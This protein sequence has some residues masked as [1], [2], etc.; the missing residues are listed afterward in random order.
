[1][2]KYILFLLFIGI[3]TESC[4]K[5]DDSPVI[6]EEQEEMVEEEVVEEEVD[7]QVQD[8]MW[9]TLNAYYFWQGD[10]PVLADNR[11]ATFVEYETYLKSHP[12]PENFLLDEL[13]F[14]GDRFTFYSEDYKELTNLLSGIS[15]SNGLEFGLSRIGNSD[16]VFGFVEYVIKDSDASTKDIKRG[17]VFI[18]VNGTELNVNN[19]IDL[20]FGESDTYTL[21]MATIENNTISPNGKEVTLTKQEGLVEDP[22]LITDVFNIG[23]KRIGYLMYNSFTPGSGE[24][25]NSVFAEFKGQNVTD[26]VLD[27]RYNSGGRVS[28][29]IILS[30]LIYGTNTEELFYRD[31]YNAKIQALFEP[32]ELENN[33]VATTGTANGNS[34]AALN[35]LNLNT[36]YV[37]A[38]GAS[39]SS[40]ELVMVGLEPYMNVVHIG[41]TTVGKNEGSITF[42]DDPENG[43][44]YDPEREDRIN[45][46]NQWALQPIV[47]RSENSA[48][49]SDYS[50]GLIPDIELEEDVTNL[51]TLGDVNEPLLARA[52]QEITGIG[53]KRSFDVSMPVNLVSSSKLY[54]DRNTALILNGLNVGSKNLLKEI[55]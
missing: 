30:S 24:A 48:G 53:A 5:N 50:D 49:F 41:T 12:N 45:P 1:M 13:L 26:L 9:Q 18:G 7:I 54:D 10:V 21:N 42:V 52:I 4:K 34:N 40:S 35:T 14:S 31:R 15:K 6:E 51:G 39:A 2:R 55:K 28:T 19:Y 16:D 37:L 43:N 8:F 33:F 29:A 46:E 11:F 44:F 22:I 38:T 25:L 23:D 17:D 3:L 36:V 27:L 32:G 47:S 20:L